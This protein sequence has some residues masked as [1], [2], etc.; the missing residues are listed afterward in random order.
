MTE[1][2]PD[3]WNAWAVI[4]MGTGGIHVIPMHDLRDHTP[5]DCWCEPCQDDDDVTIHNAADQRESY[6]MGRLPS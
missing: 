4:E 2:L 1:P 5:T 6:D 3:E